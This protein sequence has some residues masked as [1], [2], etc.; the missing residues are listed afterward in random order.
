MGCLSSFMSEIS[1]MAVDGV[2]SSESVL[3]LSIARAKIWAA[4]APRWI[5]LRA[6]TELSMRLL[7]LWTVAYLCGHQNYPVRL[8]KATYVPSPSFSPRM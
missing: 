6:T 2:P 1:R 8:V 3:A 5:S 4:E 7:P